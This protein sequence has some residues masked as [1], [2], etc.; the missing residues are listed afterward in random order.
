MFESHP[1]NRSFTG[2]KT[3]TALGQKEKNEML[4]GYYVRRI[5]VRREVRQGLTEA[6]NFEPS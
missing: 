5:I 2:A 1:K 4:F 3:P 6:N